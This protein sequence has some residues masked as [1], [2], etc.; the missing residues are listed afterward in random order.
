MNERF[1][2]A[3]VIAR[4]ELGHEP[5]F[6]LAAIEI[7]P[8]RREIVG[9]GLQ[10]TVEPRVMQVLVALARAKGEILTRDDLI[11]SCWDGL[12]V[13]EDAI[14]RCIGRL[15]KVAE[16]SGNAFAVETIPRVGYRLKVARTEVTAPDVALPNVPQPG[17]EVSAAAAAP[18][19]SPEMAESAR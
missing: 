15:R 4:V 3:G 2:R 19:S 10:E 6:V 8:S 17:S 18:L 16:A 7:R 12:I 9:A 11:E 5:D 14:N 13:G 1:V